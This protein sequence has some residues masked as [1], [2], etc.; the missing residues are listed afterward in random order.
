MNRV[1]RQLFFSLISNKYGGHFISE[2]TGD[3]L[4]CQRPAGVTGVDVTQPLR[5]ELSFGLKKESLTG[6]SGLVFKLKAQKSLQ[7]C[8][9]LSCHHVHI[10]RIHLSICNSYRGRVVYFSG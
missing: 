6:S 9:F 10:Y 4:L 7:K 8:L 3:L 2:W 1:S 5:A